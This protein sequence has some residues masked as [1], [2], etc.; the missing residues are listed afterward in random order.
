M[1]NVFE[2]TRELTYKLV[3]IPSI[4][5]VRGERE[6][7]EAIYKELE[8]INYF[9]QN[10][11]HLYRIPLKGDGLS[12]FSVAALL[13]G[14]NSSKTVILLGHID[15]VGVDEFGNISEFAFRPAELKQKLQ[16]FILSDEV[17]R[18]LND[19]RWDFGRGILDMKSGVAANLYVLSYL[20][21]KIHQIN[22][23]ILFIAAPDEEG[24]SQGILSVL[25]FLIDLRE[26][27]NLEY[28][29]VINTDYTSPRFNG[30]NSRYIYLGTIG[31]L[32]PAFYIVGKETH[33]GQC[34][35]GL[36][37]NLLSAELIRLIDNN[38]TLSDEAEG[39]IT[40]PPISLKNQDL[41]REYSVQ[42]PISAFHYFNFFTHKMSPKEVLEKLKEVALRAFDNVLARLNE[43]YYVYCRRSG[44][45]FSPLPWQSRVLSFAEV[46]EMAMDEHAE[47][48][49]K[50][51]EELDK[52]NITDEREYSLRVVEAVWNVLGDKDPVII[53][54]FAPP[55][56]PHIYMKGE[57]ENER[58]LIKAVNEAVEEVQPECEEKIVIRKFYPY[59]S[60]IS[61]LSLTGNN[62]EL[63]SL[64]ENMPAWNKKY[65]LD[66]ETIK[67]LNLP[68]VNI[69]PFGKDA[70][71]ISERIY[72]PY[73]YVT[74][75][76]LIL[77]TIK[78]LI[79][80]G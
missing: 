50:A 13:K 31:K 75:P 72:T 55:Y 34:F 56:Y 19:D 40:V 52:L 76:K 43:E 6:I 17:K 9:K 2:R 27:E 4:V 5:G 54:M 53:V 68:V 59:I 78:K 11:Q 63:M 71:K 47:E 10:P 58:L 45:P 46:Y 15:T 49:K 48:L 74:V 1:E 30:D 79:M 25:P 12:R 24:N 16:K 65:F 36:D 39:E 73:S 33:V 3:G 29:G 69:G 8:D 57:N 64:I 51:F 38:M 44:L 18:D 41:K 60:D 23:N 14:G 20:S 28:I 70:H 21:E 26:R 35:E 62:V 61:Y 66:F 67:N 22:G 32:L 7:A 77:S 37:A 42:T 80:E